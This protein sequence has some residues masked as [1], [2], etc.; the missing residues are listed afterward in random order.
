MTTPRLLTPTE[1]VAGKPLPRMLLGFLVGSQ[2]APSPDA[3][4][5]VLTVRAHPFTPYRSSQFDSVW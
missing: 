5:D 2:L 4:R 1:L 3:P